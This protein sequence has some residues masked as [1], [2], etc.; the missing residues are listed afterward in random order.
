LQDGY[1]E[2]IIVRN[3]LFGRCAKRVFWAQILAE[4][5]E[6]VPRC[7]TGETGLR[8]RIACKSMK[9]IILEVLITLG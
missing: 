5:E 6:K 9:N 8:V 4:N 2:K 7:G 3:G 1:L